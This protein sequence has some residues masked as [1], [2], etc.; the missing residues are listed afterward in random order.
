[1]AGIGSQKPRSGVNMKS[2][3]C[4]AAAAI[5]AVCLGPLAGT[6][7]AADHFHATLKGF[8]ETPANSTT[9]NGTFRLEISDDDS[10]ISFVLT[11]SDLVADSKFAHIHLGQKNVAGGVMI[12]LCDNSTPPSSPNT[13]PARGG[14]VTGTVTAANVIGPTGQGVSAGEFAKAL[15]AIRAGF[16]YA[17]VHSTKF[18]GGEIRGQLSPRHHH[19]RDGD[20]EDHD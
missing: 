5:L 12:F 13:C 8:N 14:T 11:Y 2:A 18:P 3:L 16:A 10:S 7:S 15:E 1:M 6:A 20:D 4:L 19:D 9:G 17:N